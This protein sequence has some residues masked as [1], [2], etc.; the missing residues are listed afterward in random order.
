M[1]RRQA[2]N[3]RVDDQLLVPKEL[4]NHAQYHV[5]WPLCVPSNA[6]QT[7]VT[8]FLATHEEGGGRV[9]SGLPQVC[10]SKQ[11]D[12]ESQGTPTDARNVLCVPNTGHELLGPLEATP[13]GYRCILVVCDYF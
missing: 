9:V 7:P 4:R 3:D 12:T 1:R 11:T 5:R 2:S 10:R 6:G 13:K 8:L